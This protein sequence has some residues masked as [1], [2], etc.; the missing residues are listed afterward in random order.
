MV[1]GRKQEIKKLNELYESQSAELVALYGRRRVGKTFLID[2]VFKDRITFRHSG[3][4][5]VEEEQSESFFGKSRMKSQLRHFLRSLQEVGMEEKKTPDSWQ[6][7]FY[8]LEDYLANVCGSDRRILIF[9]DEIQWLDTPKSGFMTGF[10][11]FWN[12][13]ACHRSNVMVIVCGSSSSWVLDKLINN[14]GGLYDRVTC[15][16]HLL[17]FSLKECEEF[18]QA[19]NFVISRYDIVQAYMMLGGIPYY[20]RYFSREKSLAQ[21]VEAVF[22]AEN[23]PLKY[24][25]DRLFHSLFVNPEIMKKI[26]LVLNSKSG[27]YTR[28]ELVELTGA[29]DSGEFT[30]QLKALISGGFIIRYTS[31]GQGKRKD[32]YKLFDPFCIFYLKFVKD[33][34]NKKIR[35]T[36]LESTNSVVIWRGLAFENVCFNHIAQIKNS[37]QIGGVSTEE[38]LWSKRGEEDS[39]GT[40]IDL[41]IKRKDN[42]INMCEIKFLS[43][44][45]SVNKEYHLVLENRREILSS[46][47]PKKAVVHNTL[48]TTYGLKKNEYAGDFINVVLL[49]DL[50]AF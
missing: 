44:L 2:E 21:N 28:Q 9:I 11:A 45:F 20:L 43:N 19:G 10:E 24:E 15:S 7:A 26:I 36:A 47:I 4:S 14:H 22:F 49:D 37:M 27:G 31:F 38:S 6:E 48:I 42:V 39:P 33:N 32:L 35:W 13:W 17:P 40:Q 18:F 12:G 23:A 41:I 29:N 46:M 5:P 25:F 30:N 50:F 8:L 16:I 1:I 34:L 3:L